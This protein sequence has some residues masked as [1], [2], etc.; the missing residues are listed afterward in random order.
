MLTARV[1]AITPEKAEEYLEMNTRN[2]RN[3]NQDTVNKY[4][5]DM[6][7]GRW[8]ENGA[9]ISFYENGV[10]FD[11]Q[12]R[13]KAI[14]KSGTTVKMLVVHGIPNDTTIADW[15]QKR[16]ISQWG[17]ANELDV[18]TTMGG[19]ARMILKCASAKA[20]PMGAVTQYIEEHYCGIKES[21]RLAKTGKKNP[22]GCR[23]PMVTAI[24]VVRRLGHSACHAGIFLYNG[25][26]T[27]NIY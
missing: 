10:L 26:A 15:G 9:P 22:I 23:A 6:R 1:E 4:A 12:H 5:L 17:K 11:G 16:T 2:Y 3:M 8:E 13:L 18:T 19:V 20:V 24:Y 21:E 25:R 14:A 27:Q 7:S